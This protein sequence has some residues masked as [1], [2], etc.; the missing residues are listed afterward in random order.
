MISPN[1]QAT[2]AHQNAELDGFETLIREQLSASRGS[3]SDHQSLLEGKLAMLSAMRAGLGVMPLHVD[4]ARKAE[5]IRRKQLRSDYRPDQAKMRLVEL[6]QQKGTLENQ[7]TPERLIIQKHIYEA[8]RNLNNET[9]RNLSWNE[10]KTI[11][12]ARQA[13]KSEPSREFADAAIYQANRKK[14]QQEREAYRS[15]EENWER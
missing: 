13:M 10:R 5:Y 3:N 2:L 15:Q 8:A 11:S 4:K 7:G 9:W 1:T 14:F 6:Y 12:V